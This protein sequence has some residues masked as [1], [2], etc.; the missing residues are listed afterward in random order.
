MMGKGNLGKNKEKCDVEFYIK[1]D[2]INEYNNI[3]SGVFLSCPEFKQQLKRKREWPLQVKKFYERYAHKVYDF[4]STS[5]ADKKIRELD[6]L[7]D[8]TNALLKQEPINMAELEEVVLDAVRICQ[9]DAHIS[10]W[11]KVIKTAMEAQT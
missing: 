4:K 7:A 1:E 8:K 10:R 6:D 11:R 2:Y 3:V 5:E 9:G